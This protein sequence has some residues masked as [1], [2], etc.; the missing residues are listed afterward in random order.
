[1]AR[2]LRVQ[3]EGAI[4]HVMNR[5]DRQEPIFRDDRDRE[6]FVATLGEACGMK[7]PVHKWK[8]PERAE[9]LAELDAAYFLL[10][11]ISRTDAEYIL[12]TFSSTRRRDEAE[13]GTFRTAELIL[14]AY[15]RLRSIT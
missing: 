9:L 12:S 13:T 2:K 7:N 11:G 3:Y 1:M 5:G 10:Y 15:D 14:D 8:P 4:Y 6:T